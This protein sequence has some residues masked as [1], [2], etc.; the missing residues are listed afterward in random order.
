MFNNTVNGCIAIRAAS[1]HVFMECSVRSV[2]GTILS[3]RGNRLVSTRG[4]K[5]TGP[6][7]GSARRTHTPGKRRPEAIPPGWPHPSS[8]FSPPLRPKTIELRT[9]TEGGRV[10]LY[11][12]GEWNIRVLR[13]QGVDFSSSPVAGVKSHAAHHTGH[14]T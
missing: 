11:K 5:A 13:T 3:E 1:T 8:A 4:P 6:K 14:F 12:M 9:H 7:R 2:P 10:Q